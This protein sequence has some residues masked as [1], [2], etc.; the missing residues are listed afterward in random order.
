MDIYCVVTLPYT[1]GLPGD[2]AVNTFSFDCDTPAAIDTAMSDLVS[3]YNTVHA[4]GTNPI[5]YY[6][7]GVISRG[8]NACTIEAFDRA[9]AIP[10]VAVDSRSFTLGSAA[11]GDNLPL[12]VAVTCSFR[13]EYTSGVN[14]ARKRG[15]VFLGPLK[16]TALSS[17]TGSAPFVSTP[18]SNAILGASESLLLGVPNGSQWVVWSKASNSASPVIGGWVD[19]DPDT[20]RRRSAQPTARAAWSTLT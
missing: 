7:S 19:N 15:R 6:L 20:Q 4:P 14:R 2:V 9:D 1:T 11:S 13:G 8:T 5:A 17:S 16:E 10:R 3:F 18:F 12:E